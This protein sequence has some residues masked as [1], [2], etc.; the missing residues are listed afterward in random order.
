[1]PAPARAARGSTRT[2]SP[3]PRGRGGSS[4]R[5]ALRGLPAPGAH[6]EAERRAHRRVVLAEDDLLPRELEVREPRE[7]RRE[8][9]AGLEARERC[10]EADVAAAAEAHV[11]DRGAA[12]VESV[13]VLEAARVAVR[14]RDRAQEV[15]P[16][17]ELL[18]AHLDGARRVA[19]PRER[20]RLVAQRLLD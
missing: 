13:G 4:R 20:R 15:A 3:G 1:R 18:P 2:G 14:R 6:A 8:R 16:G 5:R 9:G 10:A 7:E 11:L 12:Q 19:A 17:R